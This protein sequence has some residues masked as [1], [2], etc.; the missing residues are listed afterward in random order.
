M[1]SAVNINQFSFFFLIA[2]LCDHD[3][4]AVFK[5][6]PELCV[7]FCSLQEFFELVL[8]TASPIIYLKL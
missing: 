6:W 8:S 1:S 3:I 4:A 2:Q 7:L 5:A